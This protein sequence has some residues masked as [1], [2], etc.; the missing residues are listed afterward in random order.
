VR[1]E[2]RHADELRAVGPRRE[3][4]ADI[5]ERCDGTVRRL[6]AHTQERRVLDEVLPV[7]PLLRAALL[8]PVLFFVALFD[9][10][11]AVAVLE[12]ARAVTRRQARAKTKDISYGHRPNDDRSS[13]R[14]SMFDST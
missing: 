10:R 7:A 1:R 2:H 5:R 11:L 3:A 8:H 6:D 12:V 14:P 13:P 4:G 9:E